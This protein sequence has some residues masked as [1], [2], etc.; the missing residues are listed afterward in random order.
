MLDSA[1]KGEHVCLHFYTYGMQEV[2]EVD[3]VIFRI[4]RPWRFTDVYQTFKVL[5]DDILTLHIKVQLR[6][7]IQ[8]CDSE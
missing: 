2:R 5:T 8:L 1:E 3:K 6:F 7:E 4:N